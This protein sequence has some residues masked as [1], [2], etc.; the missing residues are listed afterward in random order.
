M[1]MKDLYHYTLST[2]IFDF[3][4]KLTCH[5]AEAAIPPPLA[6]IT[7]GQLSTAT[8]S[9]PWLHAAVSKPDSSPKT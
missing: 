5:L 7:A 6:A 3:E 2:A 1:Q 9:W 4:G 8:S